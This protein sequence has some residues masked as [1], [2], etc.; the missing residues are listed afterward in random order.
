MER[1]S[2]LNEIRTSTTWD[3][4]IIGGGAMGLGCA[5]DAANR[6]YKTLLV[7]AGDFASGTS[8]RSSKMIHGGLRYLKQ[9]EIS[10][11]RRS[12]IA[13]AGLLQTASSLVREQRIIIPIYTRY[14][15]ATYRLGLFLYDMLAGSNAAVSSSQ[16]L[17][18]AQTCEMLPGLQVAEIK[19]GVA[20]SDGLFDDA[21]LA[22]VMAQAASGL[23]AH[24]I[25]Y[26][27]VIDVIKQS[28]KSAERIAGVIA[29]DSESNQEYEIKARHVI[30]AAG[31]FVDR[32]I[33]MDNPNSIQ[34][35]AIS[36]GSHIVLP[37]SF[38]PS[39]NGML[40]P[41]TLD[42]RVMF[43]LPWHNRLLVG[44]TDVEVLKAAQQPQ[45]QSAEIDFILDNCRAYF[46]NAPTKADILSSFAG[47]RAMVANKNSNMLTKNLSRSHKVLRSDSGLISVL[48][49]KWTT[50]R[51]TAAEAVAMAMEDM[52]QNK[53][54]MEAVSLDKWNQSSTQLAIIEKESS[55]YKLPIHPK[56][57]YTKGQ[58]VAAVRYEMARKAEDVL[59]RR[60]RSLL[61]DAKAANHCSEEVIKIMAQEL[62][63]DNLWIAKQIQEFKSSAQQYSICNK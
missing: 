30:N 54:S 19:G 63:K 53:S 36:Q 28:S 56:L 42:G 37:H 13:R 1:E 12:L 14:E 46:S 6:G 59:A 8:S 20:Y 60:T 9:F 15:L 16:Y 22:I 58:V 3:L 35:Q 33:N 25:N 52:P 29:K 27:P 32:I 51:D 5:V 48:G 11:V 45:P 44:T 7:E 50:Y 23:G 62:G 26:M 34:Q 10:M 57:P 17:S 49:G 47:Q 43:C 4:V 18:A 39:T 40:I 41:K 38:L 21:R 24:L 55:E 61:L 2:T 31:T